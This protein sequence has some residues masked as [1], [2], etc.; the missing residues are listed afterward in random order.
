[1]DALKNF[2][3]S[4]VATAPSPAASG[5][6]LGVTAG[7]GALC[8]AVPFNAT[9]WP[10]GVQPLTT[11]AEIVRVTARSTDTLTIVRAQEG[12]TAR[13]IVVGDQIAQ[14]FTAGMASDLGQGVTAD[15]PVG[16]TAATLPRSSIGGVFTHSSGDLWVYSVKLAPGRRI[17]KIGFMSQTT[18]VGGTHQFFGLYDDYLGSSSGTPLARLAASADDTSTAWAA[19]TIKELAL[20]TPYVTTR[21]GTYYIT[22]LIVATT[23]PALWS[24]AGG[25][26]SASGIEPKLCGLAGSGLSALPNPLASINPGTVVVWGWV[27]EA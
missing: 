1:M 9:I 18:L 27:S 21:G 11:N 5:T 8:P 26:S 14:T 3:Y 16:A 2:V 19:N 23:P 12:T 17:T 7:Q 25:S 13:T 6:S 4:L 22:P 15:G 20:T 24:T 10:T